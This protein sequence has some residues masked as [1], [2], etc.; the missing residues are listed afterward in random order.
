MDFDGVVERKGNFIIFETK[1]FGVKIPEAQLITFRN[2]WER[3]G[4]TI[5]FI[6]GKQCP[7]KIYYWPPKNGKRRVMG[8][9]Y[10][11]DS[12]RN[13]V[14]RWYRYSNLNPYYRRENVI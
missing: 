14:S 2:M 12:A 7:E 10:G 9:Y 4:I 5:M 3:G 13:I 11:I 8:P 1:D 6:Y